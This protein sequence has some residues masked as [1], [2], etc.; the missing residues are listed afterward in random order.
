[1]ID[2]SSQCDLWDPLELFYWI[3]LFFNHSSLALL[4]SWRDSIF[5]HFKVFVKMFLFLCTNPWSHAGCMV[6]SLKHWA[7]HLKQLE[8]RNRAICQP[9]LRCCIFFIAFSLINSASAS[10]NMLT[11]WLQ[12]LQWLDWTTINTKI[13]KT[14]P[15]YWADTFEVSRWM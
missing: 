13:V 7:H 1:M 10:F 11:Y 6:R 14:E 4:K 2:F 9:C 8:K 15:F 3:L 12:L 5:R